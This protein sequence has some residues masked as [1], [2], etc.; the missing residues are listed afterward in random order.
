MAEKSQENLIFSKGNN[1]CKNR[2]SIAKLELELYYDMA[3]IN[4][5]CVYGHMLKKIRVG[6]SKI[7]C[8][9][10]LF[11]VTELMFDGI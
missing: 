9:L 5:M 2:S 10:I 8:F 11:F 6:R 4:N 7:I 1:S 3:K